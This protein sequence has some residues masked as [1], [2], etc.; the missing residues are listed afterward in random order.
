MI[1]RCLECDALVTG[2]D[3]KNHDGFVRCPVCDRR[4]NLRYASDGD[5]PHN[6]KTG[7]V[8]GM[9]AFTWDRWR[10][11]QRVRLTGLAVDKL[12]REGVLGD[13]DQIRWYH[14]GRAAELLNVE[15]LA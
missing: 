4:M 6:P 13:I 7:A 15:G 12:F 9:H 2:V 10:D 8:M 3:D 11:R 1:T 5:I 14:Y